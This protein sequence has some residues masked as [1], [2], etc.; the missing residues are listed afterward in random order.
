MPR[1]WRCSGS[2]G[3]DVESLK[4][5]L[6]R[7]M[8]AVESLA[9]AP[10]PLH[11]A[12]HPEWISLRR[13]VVAAERKSELRRAE[14]PVDAVVCAYVALYTHRRPAD[15]TIYGDAANGYIVTPSLPADLA[16]GPRS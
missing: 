14:D 1:R 6:L 16:P 13:G 9:A 11:V 12:D 4:S 2:P 15:V 3:R 5:E 8:D 10:V 7:L